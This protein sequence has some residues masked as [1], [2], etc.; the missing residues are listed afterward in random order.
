MSQ[1][2]KDGACHQLVGSR[3]VHVRLNYV[4][5]LSAGLNFKPILWRLTWN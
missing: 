5:P 1:K 4:Q 3:R 2:T